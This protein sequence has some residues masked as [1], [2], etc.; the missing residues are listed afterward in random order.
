M[1]H[2]DSSGSGVLSSRN[3]QEYGSRAGQVKRVGQLERASQPVENLS[4][5]ELKRKAA[6]NRLRKLSQKYVAPDITK[7]EIRQK[8]AE[9]AEESAKKRADRIAQK[10]AQQ[11]KNA[12]NLPAFDS[13][14]IR[15]RL[16]S[17]K[18]EDV[19]RMKD[20]LQKIN[21]ND[22]RNMKLH[23][24]ETTSSR[25]STVVK[26]FTACGSLD[27][28]CGVK[29]GGS[30]ENDEASRFD[31]LD[32]NIDFVLGE[33]NSIVNEE[34]PSTGVDEKSKGDTLGSSFET[35][36]TDSYD[37]DQDSLDSLELAFME[38]SSGDSSAVPQ[39]DA[40]L[41]KVQNFAQEN[42]ISSEKSNDFLFQTHW[43][44]SF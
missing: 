40:A 34:N 16:P 21:K 2:S 38:L 19:E 43:P 8:T 23:L 14:I 33:Q 4:A 27:T 32:E 36:T 9:L 13:K 28:L 29:E 22:V 1:F 3:S 37:D 18:R 5:D 25:V 42:G 24:Q 6:L 17:I 7:R 26:S 11:K 15:D 20:R 31:L 39:S 12:F 41:K 44:D 30:Y 10:E 35:K